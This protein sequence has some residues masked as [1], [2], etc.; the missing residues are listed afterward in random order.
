M[1]TI[2]PATLGTWRPRVGLD[3]GCREESLPRRS[4]AWLEYRR[5]R[6]LLHPRIRQITTHPRPLWWSCCEGIGTAA[7]LNA[8]DGDVLYETWYLRIWNFSATHFIDRDHGGWHPQLDG[9]LKP[10]TNPF[11]GEPDIYHVLQ[12]CLIPLFPTTGSLAHGIMS[13]RLHGAIRAD[14]ALGS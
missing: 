6:V 8:I 5:R 14:M 9:Q 2:A 13:A 10:N 3:A 11:Y 12:A 7:V 1:V 4:Q